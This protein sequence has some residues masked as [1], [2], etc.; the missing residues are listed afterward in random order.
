MDRQK[1]TKKVLDST[2][3]LFRKILYGQID[4]EIER[5]IYSI[6]SMDIDIDTYY[7]TIWSD[8]KQ[9]YR[10]KER[11]IDRYIERKKDRQIDTYYSMNHKTL[12]LKS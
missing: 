5:Q 11:Q 4:K 3:Y 2:I 9:I 8:R 10:K 1:D 12:F 6:Y 7:D